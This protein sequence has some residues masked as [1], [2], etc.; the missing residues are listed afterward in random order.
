MANNKSVC[1]VA[2]RTDGE[3][4]HGDGMH[5]TLD[6][7][8]YEG[9]KTAPRACKLRFRVP[10]TRIRVYQFIECLSFPEDTIINS[11]TRRIPN[12]STNWD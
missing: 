2:T 7:V 8:C 3:P 10:C 5:G 12:I 1:T 6:S 4:G 11:F 9:Q